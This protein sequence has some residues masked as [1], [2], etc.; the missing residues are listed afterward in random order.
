MRHESVFTHMDQETSDLIT[1]ISTR[2]GMIMEDASV[3]ALTLGRVGSE[4]RVAK[5]C[6]IADAAAKIHALT[7]AIKALSR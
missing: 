4:A 2:I 5:V 1:Q 6:E 3:I 7:E